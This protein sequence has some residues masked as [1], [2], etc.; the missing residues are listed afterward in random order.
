MGRKKS[1]KLNEE[2]E[3]IK[4]T[5]EVSAA[6]ADA[7]A[8]NVESLHEAEL[9]ITAETIEPTADIEA[10]PSLYGVPVPARQANSHCASVGRSNSMP[11]VSKRSVP[12]L[13]L[14]DTSWPFAGKS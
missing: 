8:E 7:A 5:A 14:G 12:I 13:E 9:K 2:A 10:L 4:E 11:P 6:E 1:E 3:I